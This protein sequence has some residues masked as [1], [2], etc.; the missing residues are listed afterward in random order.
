MKGKA[1]LILTGLL[2]AIFI[3]ACKHHPNLE[4][5]IA[6][7]GGD[8]STFIPDTVVIVN[9]HPCDPDSVYFTTQILPLL[10]SSCAQPECHDAITH[11]EGIRLYDYAHI[12]SSDI[13][14]VDDPY[15]SDIIEVLFEDDE[16]DMMPPPDAGGPLSAADRQMILDWILQGARNNSCNPDCDPDEFSFAANI[17]PIID[18]ACQGC[19]SGSSPDGDLTLMNYDQIRTVALDGRLMHAL[20]GTGDYTLMPYNTLG[21]PECNIT[22]FENWVAAG[23]PNN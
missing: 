8:G 22:Q 17:Y 14:D 10:I 1:A 21:L 2:I 23:A 3:A 6:E 20:H 16:D 15:D 7:G 19:H 12:M 11:E 4:N 5:L 13:I 18:L 9:P